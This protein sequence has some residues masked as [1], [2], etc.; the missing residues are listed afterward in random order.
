MFSL[1]ISFVIGSNKRHEFLQTARTLMSPGHNGEMAHREAIFERVTAPERF[2]WSERFDTRQA[3][4]TRL[5]SS[6]IHTLLGAI[7]VLGRVEGIEVYEGQPKPEILQSELPPWAGG[8][9]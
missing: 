5:H 8:E 2:V 7:D 6:T 3:L 9:A 4:E 1:E